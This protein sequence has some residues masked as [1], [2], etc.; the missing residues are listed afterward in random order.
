M[1]RLLLKLFEG[2]IN[3]VVS[4]ALL[5]AGV[6]AAYCLWDNERIYAAAEEVQAEL[7]S[8][9]PMLSAEV[10]EDTGPTFAELQAI[11]P[12]VCAWVTLDNT[13]IDY[14]VLQGAT[15]LDY[16]NTDVYGNF[17]LAGS[18]FL[19]SRNDRTCVEPYLL[20]YGHHM[21]NGSMFGDLDLYKDAA[22]FE[23]NQT[24]TI[25]LP[26]RAYSLQIFACMLVNASDDRIFTPSKWDTDVEGLLDYAETDAIHTV[27]Y[28]IAKLRNQ[29]DAGDKVQ[30]IA[31]TTC[32]S[33]FTDAR[34][35]ILAAMN[36]YSQECR[37]DV[38]R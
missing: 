10:D 22:F 18:I 2:L 25:M 1:A 31:F 12:D 35:I 3:F 37:E 33:E 16:I 4:L 20:L 13:Q 32:A 9:K 38:K 11:N 30:V 36:Q 29:I 23:E 5:T 21:E 17:A 15:N 26:A 24:G 34:T 19:D 27:P 28:A 14:P 8:L 7:L 6:Y